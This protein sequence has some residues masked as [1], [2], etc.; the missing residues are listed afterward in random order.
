MEK[1]NVPMVMMAL[2]ETSL[3]MDLMDDSIDIESLFSP[4]EEQDEVE[5]TQQGDDNTD[6]APAVSSQNNIDTEEETLENVGIEE[7]TQQ[8][9]EPEVNSQVPSNISS[10][11][12]A[13]KDDGI[14]PDVDSE[15][16]QKAKSPED[17][18]NIIE[19][20]VAARLDATQQ[21]LKKALDSGMTPDEIKTYQDTQAFLESIEEETLEDEDNEESLSLAKNLIYQDF[22]NR[23]FT[24]ERA[25]KEI[26]KSIKAGT[27]VE[28]AKTALESNKDFYKGKYEATLRERE[29]A[30]N[31]ARKAAEKL[32]QEFIKKTTE[33]KEPFKGLTLD[34][35]TRR[36]VLENATK[37]IKD[38]EGNLYTPVQKYI[39][40]NPNDAQYFMSLFYTLT[41]GFTNI[42]K[43][44]GG[45][46][47]ETTKKVV[48]NIEKVLNTSSRFNDSG[49][50]LFPKDEDSKLTDFKLDI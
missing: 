31:K 49:N 9:R 16:I 1:L 15:L 6:G 22:L 33:T 37:P 27:L 14:L 10:I 5:D 19:A 25:K 23:N 11:L 28:D 41:D 35:K 12:T 40:E 20:Q 44:V 3:T 42:D 29:E 21:F 50:A 17:F 24:P 39:K 36:V 46:V 48:S 7:Q 26:E 34:E 32:K 18:A 13:L 47:K 43:L 2:S 30:T 38:T 8:G 45:K 4:Q